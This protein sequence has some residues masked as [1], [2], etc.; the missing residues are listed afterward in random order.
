MIIWV[1][2]N[3]NRLYC[4]RKTQAIKPQNTYCEIRIARVLLPIPVLLFL[5]IR[6][7][8]KHTFNKTEFNPYYFSNWVMISKSFH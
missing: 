7:E 8:F 4:N 6:I 3:F 5:N 1:I 2:L